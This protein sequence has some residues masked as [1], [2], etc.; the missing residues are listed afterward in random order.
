MQLYEKD[1]FV[2][3]EVLKQGSRV[4]PE[5]V[6]SDRI[7]WVD[8]QYSQCKAVQHLCKKLDKII[9]ICSM[10]SPYEI[11]ARTKVQKMSCGFNLFYLLRS[12][13]VVATTQQT[14][15]KLFREF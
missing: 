12:T 13:C 15:V 6:R 1:I 7:T 10:Q 9:K 8:E 14:F 4:G 2:D 11:E 5:R 3:G